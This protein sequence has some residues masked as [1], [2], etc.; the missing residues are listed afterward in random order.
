MKYSIRGVR[1]TSAD[2]SHH[3]FMVLELNSAHCITCNW[4]GEERD[5]PYE[6]RKD[7]YDHNGIDT[8]MTRN[9]GFHILP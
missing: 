5:T 1:E 8:K 6:I 3:A 7:I 2:K 4:W 9:I